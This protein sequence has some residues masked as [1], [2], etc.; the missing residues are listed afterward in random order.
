MFQSES[1]DLKYARAM[2]YLDDDNLVNALP[3]KA[4]SCS[5]ANLDQ[6][7]P[8]FSDTRQDAIKPCLYHHRQKGSH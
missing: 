4:A 7:K 3:S 5:L 1:A 8:V 2:D 6:K